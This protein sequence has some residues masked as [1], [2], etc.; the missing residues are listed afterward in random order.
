M[1]NPRLN[2]KNWDPEERWYRIGLRVAWYD[3]K[4]GSWI[5]HLINNLH[6]RHQVGDADYHGHVT[7]FLANYPE[8]K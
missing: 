5:T 3:N 7:Y 1:S 2:R 8:F 4:S 6:D